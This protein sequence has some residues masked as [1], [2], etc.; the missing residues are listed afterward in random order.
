VHG[1]KQFAPLG[2]GVEGHELLF[3][4]GFKP[5][6]RIFNLASHLNPLRRASAL[7]GLSG[8]DIGQMG[9]PFSIVSRNF[10]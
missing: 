9:F 3:D 6:Q 1:T 5:Q 7:A 4:D 10:R 2:I 8:E